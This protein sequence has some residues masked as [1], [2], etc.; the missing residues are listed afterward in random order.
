M[1]HHRLPPKLLP[2]RMILRLPGAFKGLQ[3]PPGTSRPPGASTG[4]QAFR[5]P[6]R[7]LQG[8][9]EK[10]QNLQRPPVPKTFQ[11]PLR[12]SRVSTSLRR[13]EGPQGLPVNLLQLGG[14]NPV[15]GPPE[16]RLKIWGASFQAFVPWVWGIPIKG[17]TNVHFIYLA[18]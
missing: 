16:K 2:V 17:K 4:L 5:G 7:G 15:R 6:C 1:R 13:L 18:H 10:L 3:R 8:A 12:A 11:G 14:Q 9:P